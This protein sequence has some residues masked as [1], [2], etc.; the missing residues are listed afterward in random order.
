[1]H[2]FPADFDGG[3]RCGVPEQPHGQRKRLRATGCGGWVV[4]VM[5][6]DL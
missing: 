6:G 4:C 3:L 5:V 1:M 2:L